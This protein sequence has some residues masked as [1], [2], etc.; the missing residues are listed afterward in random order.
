[1]GYLKRFAGW[2]DDQ[3]G[4]RNEIKRRGYMP[5]Y[6]EP[7]SVCRKPS[8]TLFYPEMVWHNLW[9]NSYDH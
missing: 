6:L 4:V 8:T 7:V 9:D 3:E 2:A 5:F 1:M